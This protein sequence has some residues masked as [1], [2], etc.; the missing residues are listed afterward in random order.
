[1]IHDLVARFK[2]LADTLGKKPTRPE[3]IMSGVTCGMIR[4]VGGF[5]AIVK[6]AGFEVY[7]GAS[8]TVIDYNPKILVFDIETAPILAYVW[9]LFDQNVGLNQIHKDWHV[10][11]WSA[12]W[13]G[14]K[15]VFY[16]D[17]RNA[18][19]I[20]DDSEILKIIWSLLDE[21]DI[22]LT[23]NGIRFDSKKLNARF[24]AN[25]FNPPSSYRHIDTCVLAKK[26][27]SFTSNKLEYMTHKFNKRYKKLKHSKFSGFELWSECLRGNLKAWDEMKK[28][29]MYDVL[30]LEELY[31]NTLRKW[32]R[33]INYSVFSSSF[34]HRCS[35]GSTEMV[36]HKKKKS[37]NSG[38]F[39]R[40]TC[41]HC[42]NEM[43]SRVNEL[44]K[45]KRGSLLKLR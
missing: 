27:F 10:M 7:N 22:V 39:K 41:F 1:M 42:G 5:N 31:L 21:A 8:A 23:Q 15:E 3:F 2:K 6:A 38:I 37:T 36:E 4:S 20:E 45:V 9:G 33:S 13:V 34:E 11:S 28:Y 29:N 35:C 18:K 32:D 40:Y 16:H 19:S 17:Q 26:Y 43:F 14:Q 44:S 30:A 25:G 12:K 24:V